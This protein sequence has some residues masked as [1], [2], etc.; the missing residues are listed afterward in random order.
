MA[1]TFVGR[2]SEEL[3]NSELY[4][5]FEVLQHIIDEPS[6]A[7]LGPLTNREGA[8]W[9]DRASGGNLKFKDDG[10]WKTVF[11]DKFRMIS[12][13][14]SPEEPSRP[15]SGQL[16]LQDGILMYFSGSEWLP[17]KSVNVAS[18]FNLSAFEQFLI[19]SPIQ[20]SG[21]LVVNENSSNAARVQKL[22]QE[23]IF[24]VTS[25]ATT[26]TLANGSFYMGTNAINIYVDGKKMPKSYFQE[27]NETTIRITKDVEENRVV[28]PNKKVLVVI[29]YMNKAAYDQIDLTSTVL[30]EPSDTSSQFLLPSV[31][32]DRFFIDG[33]NVTNYK[34]ISDVAIEYPSGNL[35][36]KFASAIH[37]NPK[38]LTNVK[39]RL[40]K[41]NRT[42]PIIPVTETF[43]EYYGIKGG[44][45][46]CLLKAKENTEYFSVAQGIQLSPATAALYDFVETI[47]Y[48][49]KDVKGTGSLVKGN[50]NLSET[51]SIYIGDISD[52]LCVFAQGLYLD[53]DPANYVYED[54]FLK[55]KLENKMDI[56]VIAFS[57]KETGTITQLNTAQKGIVAINQTYNRPLVFV[58]GEN[59][60]WSLANYEVDA[61]NKKKIYVKDTK[62]GMKYAIVETKTLDPEEEMFFLSGTTQKD[63]YSQDCYITIP[64]GSISEDDN[65]ILFVN[66]LLISKKDITIDSANNR[67]D[68]FG[69]FR[70][71]LDYVILKDPSDRFLFSDYVSFNTIP[72]KKRSDMTLVY[73]ENQ[74]ATDAK[75]VY[76]SR[77][78]EKGYDGEVKQLIL[79]EST[80]WYYYNSLKGWVKITDVAEIKLLD[81][82][83]ASYVS[84]EYTINVLQ[85]FGQKNCVYYSYQYA[86][87]VEQPLLRGVI[88]TLE[89]KDEYKTA[90]NHVFP[91]NKNALA[92]WQ[93]GLRQYPDTTGNLEDFNGYLE[94]GNS[95]FKMPNPVDGIM[96]YVVEKPEGSETKSCERQVLTRADIVEGYTNVFKTDIPL[97]PGNVRVFVSGL[98]QP[99]SAFTILDNNLIKIND[100]ILAYANN[101]PT[102]QI[103]LED[104]SYLEINHIHP[105]NILIEVRQDLS[106]K[107]ITLPIRYSGQSEWSVAARN[108][109]D[110][111][112]G[113]D[114]LPESILNSKDFIMIY[115]NGMAYGKD[116]RVDLDQGKILLTNDTITSCLGKDPID[117]YFKA[118]PKDYEAWR[119]QNG[120]KE[121]VAKKNKDTITFEWR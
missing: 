113:G 77:L 7:A 74:L 26:Y 81:G 80:D 66:G 56:S 4:K 90:F 15:V 32:Y 34:E 48:E 115:I 79:N 93:N 59:L 51:T 40:F 6:D 45:G 31:M 96:F 38:K 67:I 61:V 19:I 55:L 85:N 14:L 22:Y 94:I 111:T 87:S 99:E 119:V 33:M 72:L 86:N 36:G 84:D 64:E 28:P 68:V 114:G 17:V 62:V 98:R 88:K 58:Y 112:K 20:A 65:I 70:E 44:I 92:I 120:G 102:E 106:L 110:I 41:I 1:R 60:E 100:E 121:Y 116:Y 104:G 47:T 13:I 23:E 43:T 63:L 35:Q 71:G 97:L 25:V 49:F 91:I 89:S 82:S 83:A 37:V 118:N 69:G 53:S 29:E 73:I 75:A 9:L 109:E 5:L 12:E 11:D 16:W 42:N 76:T 54:G 8:I 18:E 78:P 95:K 101:F 57:K 24:N 30:L 108:P 50:V 27:V 39:K 117:E 105:D 3:Y 21:K 107:E 46:K 52:P 2:S 10:I 103:Q